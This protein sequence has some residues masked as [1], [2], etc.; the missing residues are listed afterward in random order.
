MVSTLTIGAILTLLAWVW[1]Q[2][3]VIHG[4]Y[5]VDKIAEGEYNK[6]PL[7]GRDGGDSS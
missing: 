6:G 3:A 4:K 7:Q 5:V 2:V 1:L